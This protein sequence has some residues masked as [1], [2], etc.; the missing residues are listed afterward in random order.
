MLQAIDDNKYCHKKLQ[1][2]AD[3]KAKL[4]TNKLKLKMIYLTSILK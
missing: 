3:A 2:S 4:P 1:G